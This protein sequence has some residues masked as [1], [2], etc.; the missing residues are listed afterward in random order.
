MERADVVVVGGGF[1]GLCAARAFSNAGT[2]RV[3]VLEA[4]TGTDPRF[5]GELIHPPGVRILA[6]LGLHAP[7]LDAGGVDVEGFSVVL[8]HMVPPI[9]LP[10]TEVQGGAPR[11]LAISH[12]D[13]VARLRREVTR[14]PAVEVRTGVRVADLVY[15]GDR[16]VGVRTAEG[17]EIRA[18][19]TVVA[20]G[21]HSKLRRALGFADETRLLSFTAALLVEG[22]EL[23]RPAYGHVFLGTSGPILAYAIGRGRVRMCVDLPVETG[24]GHDA[25]EAFLREECAPSVPEPLRTA[26]L[27]SLVEDP[28]EICANHAIKTRRCAARGVA[29]V[30]DSGG[31]SHP[32]TAAGMTVALNDIRILVAELATCGAVGGRLPPDTPR[33]SESEL[34]SASSGSRGEPSRVDAALERYQASRYDFVRA[35]EILADGIYDVFRRGDDGARVMRSGLS[36]YWT[37]GARARAA[38]MALL[39]GHESRLRAFVA[40]YVW[41]VGESAVSVLGGALD[42]SVTGGRRAAL[43]GLARSA[44]D[45]LQRTI[46]LVYAELLRRASS[47]PRGLPGRPPPRPARQSAGEDMVA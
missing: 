21:R 6:E 19:L 44:Y 34:R 31:C 24:K 33:S 40:E 32:I 28:P 22:A 35:R 46:A 26:M 25:V 15:E 14:S 13:M 9:A 36:R 12:P 43:G 45:Q 11:G 17:G 5:R 4:R 23:P 41:V 38:S 16:V 27:R 30:G 42:D 7:L 20:E 8:H 10:Y 39:S 3:L 47:E 37:S 29:L 1:A 2:A 18:P